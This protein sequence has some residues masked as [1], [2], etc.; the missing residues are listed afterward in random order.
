LPPETALPR[1]PF[2]SALASADLEG[3]VPTAEAREQAVVR[4]RISLCAQ[5]GRARAMLAEDATGGDPVPRYRAV[6]SSFLRIKG[7]LP[8]LELAE[9]AENGMGSCAEASGP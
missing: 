1:S 5:Q 7:A 4:L 6:L 9:L 3:P 2:I 8:G